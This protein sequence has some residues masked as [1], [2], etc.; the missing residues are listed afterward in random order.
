M[1]RLAVVSLANCL[2][3]VYYVYSESTPICG[4]VVPV[5]SVDE[6]DSVDFSCSMSYRW[7]SKAEQSNVVPLLNV[8]FGWEQDSNGLSTKQLFRP[9]VAGNEVA[10]MTVAAA[11]KPIIPS[12]ECTIRFT[13]APAPRYRFKKFA[14][15]PVWYTCRTDPIPVRC[16]YRIIYSFGFE[17][18]DS[19][20]QMFY[21][22]LTL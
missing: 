20:T 16:K 15:N 12:Q 11:K 5:S 2:V 8:S 19:V 3:S 18:R 21:Q 1:Q 22:L 14:V 13:F 6:N 17:R 10:T 9:N 7:H 4:P